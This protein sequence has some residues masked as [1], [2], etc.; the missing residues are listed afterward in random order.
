MKEEVEAG[1][2]GGEVRR[3]VVLGEAHR[4][5]AGEG[6]RVEVGDH[7]VDE[8]VVLVGGGVGLLG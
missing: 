4:R 1:V 3:R 6:G 2:A 8:G 5:A 7:E